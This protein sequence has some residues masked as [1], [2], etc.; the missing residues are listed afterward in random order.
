VWIK[1]IKSPES[2]LQ[3]GV[4]MVKVTGLDPT[5]RSVSMEFQSHAESLF[6]SGSN[7]NSNNGKSQNL[8]TFDEVKKRL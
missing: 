5:K 2:V 6:Q 8:F 7:N 1:D 3:V 4:N